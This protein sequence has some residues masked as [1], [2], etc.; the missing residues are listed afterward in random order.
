MSDLLLLCYHAVSER[1]PAPLSVRPADFEA[2][3]ASLANRGYAG[4][5]LSEAITEPQEGR[6][7]AITFDDAFR[8]VYEIARPILAA[9]GF[10]ASVFAPTAFIGS[11]QPMSWP[12]VEQWVASDHR[13][14]LVPMSW[15]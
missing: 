6:T 12:G 1:W 8:S 15:D 13:A 2:H 14:E 11:E 5:T 3:V 10:R 7:V 9:A 4:V